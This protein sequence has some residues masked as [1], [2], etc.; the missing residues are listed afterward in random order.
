MVYGVG[1]GQ[2]FDRFTKCLDVIAHELT[3]GISSSRHSSSTRTNRVHSTS[4]CQTYSG[5]W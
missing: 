1:D 2:L 5:Q 4:R 3:H